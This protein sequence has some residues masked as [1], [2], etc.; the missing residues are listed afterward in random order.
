MSKRLKRFLY[1]W[2]LPLFF[3]VLGIILMGLAFI[4]DPDSDAYIAAGVIWLFIDI[5]CLIFFTIRSIY[6][7]I[8]SIITYRRTGIRDESLVFP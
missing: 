7:Y 2:R 4:L 3:F 1:Y 5:P 6:L 8:R